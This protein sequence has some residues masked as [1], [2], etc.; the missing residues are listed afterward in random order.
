MVNFGS[1]SDGNLAILL[2]DLKLP[3]A[4]FGRSFPSRRQEA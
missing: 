4:D 3:K 2:L 1:R